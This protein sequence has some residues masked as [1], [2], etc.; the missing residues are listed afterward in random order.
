MKTLKFGLTAIIF[1]LTAQMSTHAQDCVNA[2]QFNNPEGY[3]DFG[4]DPTAHI[5][6]FTLEAWVY[7]TGETLT[8]SEKFHNHN[9]SVNKEGGLYFNWGNNATCLWQSGGINTPKGIIPANTWVHVAFSQNQRAGMNFFVNGELAYNVPGYHNIH[10]LDCGQ[11]RVTKAGGA[12]NKIAELR[13][14]TT[15]RSKDEIQKGMNV[16]LK[17]DETN[18]WAL[19]RFEQGAGSNTVNDLSK[20]KKNGTLINMKPGNAWVATDTRSCDCEVGGDNTKAIS[21][22]KFENVEGYVDFGTKQF[23]DHIGQF[24]AEAWIN[25]TGERLALWERMVGF[26]FSIN[27]KGGLYFN[28]G[29]NANCVWQTGGL[30]TKPNL[31]PLN[32]WAHVAFRQN[33]KAGMDFF[34][35][36]VLVQN[37]T[38][39]H[40]IHAK[41]CGNITRMFAGKGNKVAEFRFWI[42]N[43]SN[44]EIKDNMNTC[45][46]GNEANLW[47]LYRFEAGANTN[48]VID[49]TNGNQDGKLVN[50]SAAT[51]WIS[52]P[53]NPCK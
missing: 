5:E 27:E 30:N 50:M 47:A 31:V 44:A 1:A 49:L 42:T 45:L 34:V 8:I 46:S 13:L 35:N 24:T 41:D 52:S 22:I 10:A 23:D 16:C 17:G 12:G 25:W 37:I 19:Y 20:G 14:W 53:A 36:G 4:K 33:Q 38:G 9:F 3:I 6:K 18:L 40:N 28:W 7:W 15:N 43:R 48:K 2:I 51:S 29:N 21:A 39:W 26:N 11:N 32:E